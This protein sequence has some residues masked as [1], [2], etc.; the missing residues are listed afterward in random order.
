MNFILYSYMWKI[1]CQARLYDTDSIQS[2]SEFCFNWTNG[3]LIPY[4]FITEKKEPIVCL[5]LKRKS[6]IEND[7]HVHVFLYNSI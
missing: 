5:K 2:I 4:P 7:N 3:L 1:D 6:Y